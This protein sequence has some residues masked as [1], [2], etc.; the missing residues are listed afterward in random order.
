MKKIKQ[1]ISVII[2]VVLIT[3]T[4]VG[5]AAVKASPS[6]DK[7]SE[8]NQS[9]KRTAKDQGGTE[10]ELPENVTKV[11]DL[12][13]ANN[14]I[15][16]L[17]GGAD[18]LVATTDTVK[19]MKW[20]AKVYPNIKD[21]KAPLSGDNI[22]AEELMALK[23]DVVLSSTDAQIEAARN[24]GLKAVKVFFQ[25]LKDMRETI[26][27]TAQVLG[28][29]A[30]KKAD[31]YLKYFDGNIDYVS[32]KTKDIPQEK[33]PKVLHIVGGNNLLNVDGKNTIIDEWI[34]LSGGVNALDQN[35][36]MINVTMEDIVKA[37]PD[38]IIIGG[39]DA[40]KGK[41]TILNSPEWASINAVKNNKIY[42]NPVGAYNWDRYSAEEALQILWAAK[43]FNPDSFKDLDLVKKTQEF[44]KEFFNYDLSSDD[45]QKII[46]GLNP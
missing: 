2:S 44:Y 12:W 30:E 33:K 38:I 10:V 11:A 22:Q 13:H 21:V 16:L 45:A 24:A 28:P 26:K 42:F 25:N 35:G 36:N 7:N 20:F 6:A 27:I 1:L 31:E 9:A 37:N 19:N 3:S 17:L 4:V 40:S 5:C 43:I 23:P 46:D 34:N 8:A 15:V 39:T 14:E 32:Q 29:D 41:E 18:K